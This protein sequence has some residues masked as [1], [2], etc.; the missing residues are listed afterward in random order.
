MTILDNSVALV[1]SDGEASK[2]IS[3]AK[4]RATHL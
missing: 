3:T 1:G 4:R 2:T